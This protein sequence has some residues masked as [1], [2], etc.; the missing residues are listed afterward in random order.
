MITPEIINTANDKLAI[1]I[2]PDNS[3]HS[4]A[5]AGTIFLAMHLSRHGWPIYLLDVEGSSANILRPSRSIT[6]EQVQELRLDDSERHYVFLIQDHK[7]E[8]Y[9]KLRAALGLIS[10]EELAQQNLQHANYE[11]GVNPLYRNKQEQRQRAF[12][13][14]AFVYLNLVIDNFFTLPQ[15]F[16]SFS[17]IA[18]CNFDGFYVRGTANKTRFSQLALQHPSILSKPI[19]TGHPV[20][21]FS[22]PVAPKKLR[23][24]YTDVV[25]RF[26]AIQNIKYF[27]ATINPELFAQVEFVDLSS[28]KLNEC[29]EKLESSIAYICLDFGNEYSHL[30]VEA[31]ASR[32][33]VLGFSGSFDL[34]SDITRFT[35]FTREGDYREIAIELEKILLEYQEQLPSNPQYLSP[36]AVEGGAFVERMFNAE[37]VMNELLALFRQNGIPIN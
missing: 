25:Y 33:V 15:S 24:C 10:L 26:M 11:Q 19:V 13:K 22:T 1:F 7:R 20:L 30:M 14:G 37:Q 23:V 34:E 5:N 8:N 4:Y 31:M 17:D 29:P 9:A 3:E 2:V 12:G 35:R 32:N 36:L 16:S 27:L 28:L 21:S 6:I 18:K